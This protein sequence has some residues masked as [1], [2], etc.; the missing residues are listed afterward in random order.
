[1][2][3]NQLTASTVPGGNFRTER[4]AAEEF[5]KENN[6]VLPCLSGLNKRILIVE[7]NAAERRIFQ[8]TLEKKT[9]VVVKTAST[10]YEAGFLTQTF[11]PDLIL[12]DIFLPD[13]DGR[14][15]VKLLRLNPGF[16]HT[17]I[18][19]ISGTRDPKDL[20]EIKECGVNAFLQKPFTPTELT[21]KIS[22]LLK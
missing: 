7:D 4:G 18:V 12:I 1:M 14:K 11:K 3:N 2:T 20:K 17:I 8:Q 19:A 15:V 22:S 21:E 9:D 13:I 10:G 16:R 6:T 5:L